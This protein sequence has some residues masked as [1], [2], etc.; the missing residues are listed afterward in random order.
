MRQKKIAK[1]ALYVD[2]I[3]AV[4]PDLLW[5]LP[6]EKSSF[7]PYTV[8]NWYEETKN[9][10]FLINKKLRIV[11]APTNRE[12]KGSDI[13]LKSLQ[14]LKKIFIDEIEI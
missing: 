11:H 7:L 3:F 12:C 9:P 4:N 10:D 8:A 6:P 5:F 2:H 13:I 1:F 14:K